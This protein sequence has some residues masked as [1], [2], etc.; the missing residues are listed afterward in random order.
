MEKIRRKIHNYD[1]FSG[2]AW[3]VPGVKGV[4]TLLLL[5]LAGTLLG[6]IVTIIITACFG[7]EA[8]MNYGMLVAY[9]L[10]FVPA[11]IYVGVVS[12]RNMLFEP[13]YALDSSHFGQSGGALLAL[14]CAIAVIAAAFMTDF[15]NSLLPPMP[16]VLADALKSLTSGELWV[17]LLC[18]SI[19]APVFEEWLCRGLILRGL[20]NAKKEDGSRVSSPFWAIVLSALIFADPCQPLAGH[21]RLRAGLPFR[22]RVLPHRFA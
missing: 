10:S 6:S 15:L 11:L 17:D 3:Y 20:L 7:A 18:V 5:F 22:L 19:F 8:A 13:G 14:L 16:D 1:V 21:P 9:P 4:I 2:H 12:R